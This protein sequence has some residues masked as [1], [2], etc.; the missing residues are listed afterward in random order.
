MDDPVGE[1]DEKVLVSL[2]LKDTYRIASPSAA[3]VTIQDNDQRVRLDASD[4]TAAEPG[5]DTGEFTFTRFGATN[6]P[7]QVFFTISGTAINGVDYAAI[8]NSVVIPAGSLTATL[9]IL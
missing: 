4:F 3:T 7:L 1:R 8:S 5:L 2:T 6:T 9:P